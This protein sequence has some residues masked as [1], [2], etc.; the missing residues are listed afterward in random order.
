MKKKDGRKSD[1]DD[2][3]RGLSQGDIC[4]GSVIIEIVNGVVVEVVRGS[5]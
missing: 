2:I 3:D 5:G 1:G 4:G